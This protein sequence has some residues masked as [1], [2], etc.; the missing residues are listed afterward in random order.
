MYRMKF[1]DID[2]IH[3]MGRVVQKHTRHYQSDFEIDKK[4]LREAAGHQDKQDN[5]FL[6]LCRTAGTWLLSERNVF[7]KDT[8]ENNIFN[9]YAEQ[10]SGSVLAFAVKVKKAVGDA[11]IGDIYVLD[12]PAHDRHIQSVGLSA[13]TVILRYERGE[14]IM[15]ADAVPGAC[16]D[17]EYGKLMSIRYLPHKQ[18]ELEELLWRERQERERYKEGNPDAFIEG[19]AD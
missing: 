1:S 13:E 16:P 15:K 6:W 5:V 8:S 11:V 2:M 10:S 3:F 19:L 17:M 14:R 9:Y 4:M 7:L 18:E 12:Y